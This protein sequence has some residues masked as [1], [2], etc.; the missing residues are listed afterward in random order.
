MIVNVRKCQSCVSYRHVYHIGFHR[1]SKRKLK[2]PIRKLSKSR[3]NIRYLSTPEKFAR[4]S[5]LRGRYHAQ[6]SELSASE[7]KLYK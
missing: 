6:S 2:S 7:K 4:Y 1:W 5:D 3:V